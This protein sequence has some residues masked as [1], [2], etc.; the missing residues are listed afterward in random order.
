[1]VP[2]TDEA[3]NELG[4]IAGWPAVTR[5][6]LQPLNSPACLIYWRVMGYLLSCLSDQERDVMHHKF[7]QKWRSQGRLQKP[8]RSNKFKRRQSPQSTPLP[9]VREVVTPELDSAPP[10]STLHSLASGS[11][12]GDSRI[13]FAPQNSTDR[14]SFDGVSGTS[15]E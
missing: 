14:D 8:A 2:S 6:A 13:G 3:M 7:G 15:S 5:Y 11:G 9:P 1:M 12:S 4:R 10:N